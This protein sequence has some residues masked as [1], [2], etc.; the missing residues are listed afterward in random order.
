MYLKPSTYNFTMTL[1]T[2]WF[3]NVSILAGKQK[4]TTFATFQ[5][6]VTA[7]TNRHTQAK[8]WLNWM[9]PLT[10][11]ATFGS[12]LGFFFCSHG[13]EW[14]TWSKIY[15]TA[16]FP[17]ICGDSIIGIITVKRILHSKHGSTS[18]TVLVK[19]KQMLKILLTH[20]LFSTQLII[21]LN[22]WFK[23]YY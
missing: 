17:H 21:I 15:T 9:P 7:D 8:S 6:K 5:M 19:E 13:V 4:E 3:L 14:A 10:P 18:F 12:V 11:M 23:F 2:I 20:G 22:G 1:R 16:F